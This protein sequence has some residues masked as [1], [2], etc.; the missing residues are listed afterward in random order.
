MISWITTNLIWKEGRS[1]FVVVLLF[2][3]FGFFVWKPLFWLSLLFCVWSFYFFRNPQRICP[4][5]RFDDETLICPA[6]GRVVDI[7]H[8]PQNQLERE[9]AYKVSIFLSAFDVHVNWAPMA[10]NVDTVEY[11]PGAFKL[12]FLPKSSFLNEHNDIII[13]GMQCRKIL[14][15]QIAGLVARRICCWVKEGERLTAGQKYG[16]IKF[17]SRVD[18]FLPANVVINVKKGQHVYGGQT[19]LG[20][21][22]CC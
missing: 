14:V 20:R 5:A 6:D 18:I 13:S 7:Q 17:G 10:G 11:T 8:D 16:M 4:A 22:I 19:I 21:W 9:Y 1:I 3:F 15:R 12:A 2:A